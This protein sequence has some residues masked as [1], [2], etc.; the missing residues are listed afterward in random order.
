MN[1]VFL[2]IG[3]NLGNEI[4]NINRSILLIK[5]IDNLELICHSSIYQSKPMY[6]TKQND[7]LNLVVEISTDITP[8]KLLK[9][10]KDIEI[11]IGRTIQ[12][13]RNYPRIIDIDI[14]DYDCIILSHKNLTLPHPKI[15]ERM[16]VLK[17]W[18][19]IAPDYKLPKINKT[20]YELMSI[21]RVENSTK[22]HSI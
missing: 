2:S 11:F 14:L 3:S 6:Y 13:K 18:S 5:Q 12:H 10:I 1:K 21:L 22:L 8:L 7:F 4:N 17:P 20:I 19:D 9:K 16:F 15:L